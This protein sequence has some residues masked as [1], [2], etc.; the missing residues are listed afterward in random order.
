MLPAL[1]LTLLLA[2]RP[3][4]PY[5]IE[6]EANTAA[7]FPYLS[8]FGTIRLHIYPAGVRAD[9]V[10]LN[11]FS[12]LGT[13]TVTIMNPYGRMYTTMPVSE[14]T[15]MLQKV[16]KEDDIA[17]PPPIARPVSGKVRG[18]PARRYR[19]LY[20]PEAW[21]DV[22]T[23][24]AIPENVQ[25][26]RIV[27]AFV[28]GISPSTAESW[29]SIP[30]TPLYVEL[31]FRRYKKLPLIRLKSF[32]LN[33]VGQEDALRVGSLYFKVPLVESIWK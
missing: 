18:I 1:A 26:R 14:I 21:I 4:Q 31:N 20:G 22:W 32:T 2:T 8:R 29:K 10:W 11:G 17:S 30:G 25:L 28:R 24:E 16:K 23:T 13:P 9:S 15:S 3:P 33:N 5:H 7:P 19:M 27:D 12:R 6:L